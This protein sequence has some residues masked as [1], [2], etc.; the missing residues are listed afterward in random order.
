MLQYALNRVIIVVVFCCLCGAY[1]WLTTKELESAIHSIE[2]EERK[3]ESKV[4]QA[5]G[6]VSASPFIASDSLREA[7]AP[8]TSLKSVQKCHM[9]PTLHKQ[10]GGVIYVESDCL[11]YFARNVISKLEHPYVLLVHEGAPGNSPEN[12]R[13]RVMPPQPDGHVQPILKR[14]FYAGRLIGYH[15]QNLWWDG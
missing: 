4:S 13:R 7:I 2:K 14:E 15:G 6:T 3:R 9:D 5:G 11:A 8:M 1:E 10:T 12:G